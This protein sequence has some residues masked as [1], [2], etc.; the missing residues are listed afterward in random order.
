MLNL[1]G[2]R[3]KWLLNKKISNKTIFSILNMDFILH[4]IIEKQAKHSLTV[5][6]KKRLDYLSVVLKSSRL[7]SIRLLVGN[8]IQYNE[9]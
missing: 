8:L 3:Y 4:H 9:C 5:L 6:Q 1:N 2:E 7:N